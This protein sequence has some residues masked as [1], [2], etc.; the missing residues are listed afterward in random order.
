VTPSSAPASSASIAAPL[1]FAHEG[2][3]VSPSVGYTLVVT[4][5]LIV[6]AGVA[7][8]FVRRRLPSTGAGGDAF[9]PRWRVA[10]RLRIAP[11]CSAAFL[12]RGD[13]EWMVVEGRGGVSVTRVDR[14]SS[15][16]AAP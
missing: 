3:D 1:N 6:L 14:G 10:Q 13:A 9:A 11:G 15:E 2:A 12:V 7:L 5:A 4:L 8:W 16:E